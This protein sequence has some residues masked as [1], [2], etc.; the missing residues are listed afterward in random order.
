[1]TKIEMRDWVSSLEGMVDKNLQKWDKHKKWENGENVQLLY[2][3]E[4]TLIK[5]DIFW[6]DKKEMVRLRYIGPRPNHDLWFSGLN[7]KTFRE[8]QHYTAHWTMALF[9]PP[10]DPE[11]HPL[12]INE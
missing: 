5:I 3:W 4:Q 2:Q 7:N 1:M 11:D 8:V 9:H 10:I 6:D 12:G